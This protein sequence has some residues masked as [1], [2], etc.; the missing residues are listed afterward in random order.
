ML[1]IIAGQDHFLSNSNAVLFSQPQEM[2][3]AY[4]SI[5]SL[6]QAKKLAFLGGLLPWQL[7][8]YI[9]SV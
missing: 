3:D 8:N 6:I 1:L 7:E 4:V 5:S 9:M 2:V